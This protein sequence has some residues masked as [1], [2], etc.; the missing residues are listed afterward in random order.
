MTHK[1]TLIITS[2]LA[3]LLTTFHHS[4]DVVRGMAPG[5]LNNLVPVV[6]LLIWLWGTLMLAE[7]RS[8]YVITLVASLLASGLPLVHM[9]GSGLTNAKIA[10]AG[11][12]FFFAWTLIALSVTAGFSVILSVRGLWN[13]RRKTR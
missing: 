10:S 11:G 8:G 6:F 12:A 2:L 5:G 4:D 13:L 7:R 3:M 1:V 9:I